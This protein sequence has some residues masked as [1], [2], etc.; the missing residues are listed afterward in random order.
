MQ[1][2]IYQVYRDN[3][4]DLLVVR[5]TQDRGLNGELNLDIR[6]FPGEGVVLTG[7][8]RQSVK[9]ADEILATIYKGL[10]NRTNSSLIAH[11]KSSRSH[12]VLQ[13]EISAESEDETE[14]KNGKHVRRSSLMFVDLAGSERVMK[15]GSI[16]NAQ[17]LLEAQSINKSIATLGLCIHMLSASSRKGVNPRHIPF[18]DCKLTRLLA[19]VSFFC[20]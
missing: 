3:I 13:F 8:T 9:D 17:R 4:S 14:G 20:T 15:S 16:N 7:L 1:L 10:K 18:R 5:S 12:V 11:D 2:S 19:E 6:E